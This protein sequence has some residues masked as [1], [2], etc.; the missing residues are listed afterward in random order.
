[1]NGHGVQFE[2]RQLQKQKLR[3]ASVYAG[4]AAGVEAAGVN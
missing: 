1:M 2:S 4:S 3:R